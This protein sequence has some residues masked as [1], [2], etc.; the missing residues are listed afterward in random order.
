MLLR[1]RDDSVLLL[2]GSS[3]PRELGHAAISGIDSKFQND[4][5]WKSIGDDFNI[6]WDNIVIAV[7]WRQDGA[8][9]VSTPFYV[10]DIDKHPKIRLNKLPKHQELGEVIL[11]RLEYSKEMQNVDS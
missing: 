10:E 2:P 4:Y 8:L 1:R 9:M 7:A 6:D 11:G 5:T 3:E